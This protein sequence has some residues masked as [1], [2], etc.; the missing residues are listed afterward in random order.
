MTETWEV[1]S[2]I[3]G[4][5]IVGVFVYLSLWAYGF[6]LRCLIAECRIIK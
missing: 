5:L 4:I 1:I 2:W 3:I 6:D